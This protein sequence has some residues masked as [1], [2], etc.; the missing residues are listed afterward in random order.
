MDVTQ[1]F[2]TKCDEILLSIRDMHQDNVLESSYKLRISESD[3]F[4]T[5]FA[6]YEQDIVQKGIAPDYQRLKTMVK[7][8]LGQKMRT[9][10]CEVRTERMVKGTPGKSGSNGKSVSTQRKQ[11]MHCLQLSPR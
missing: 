5:V 8:F 2:D 1:G 10:N 7:M 11:V 9:R 4:K 3:Q 6:L